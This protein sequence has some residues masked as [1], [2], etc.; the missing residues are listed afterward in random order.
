MEED[1]VS[2]VVAIYKSEKFLDKLIKSIIA[3]TYKNLEVFLVDDG[4]PD[5]SDEICDRYAE[6]DDRLHVIHKKNGGACEARNVGMEHCTG[7]YLTIIDGDDWLAQDYVEYLVNLIK[8]PGVDMALTDN[9]FTTRDQVQNE[10]D[11]VQVITPEEAT[12][13]LICKLDIGPWNK[14]YKLDNIRKNNISFSVP[15]SGE[16]LYFTVMAAQHS[17][18]IAMGHRK[19]Y[20]YRMNNAGS[21]LTHYNVQMGTNALWNI[22]HIG[23]CLV[24]RTKR[25]TNAVNWH[26]WKNNYF[27]LTL[28][29]GS[30]TEEE[31]KEL[32]NECIRYLRQHA[33]SAISKSEFGFRRKLGMIHIALDPMGCAR[34][35]I[36]MKNEALANDT[37][38]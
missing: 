38:E 18:K 22:K 5:N 32:V 29:V 10:E 17:K 37:M 7:K 12:V 26:I 3:Q 4:S 20:N 34:K 28:I 1:K 19:I 21:G 14:L 24:V 30:K 11:H 6:Q 33:F 13:Q 8:M 36:Q 27:T 9:I 23:E 31:N 2:I 15:W 35:E 25:T 16:G